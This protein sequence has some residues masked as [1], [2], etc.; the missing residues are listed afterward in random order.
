MG[1]IILE[2]AEYNGLLDRIERLEK[3]IKELESRREAC[4]DCNAEV[5]IG[6]GLGFSVP[7]EEWLDKSQARPIKIVPPCVQC[8]MKRMSNG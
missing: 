5:E 4:T 1:Q 8:I 7:E 2:I 3:R 6:T